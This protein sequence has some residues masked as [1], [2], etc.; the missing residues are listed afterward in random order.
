MMNNSL[1]ITLI[2]CLFA[3]QG[4]TFHMIGERGLGVLCLTI[5]FACLVVAVGCLV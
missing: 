2:A 4:A 1:I 3:L 5:T